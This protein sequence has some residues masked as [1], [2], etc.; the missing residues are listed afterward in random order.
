MYVVVALRAAIHLPSGDQ[1]IPQAYM[2]GESVA[3]PVPSAFTM[4]SGPVYPLL[5]TYAI[6][7]ECGDHCGECAVIFRSATAPFDSV[8]TRKSFEIRSTYAI[9]VP[10]GDDVGKKSEPGFWLVT[11]APPLPSG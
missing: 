9:W 2:F 4:A 8:N 11:W 5:A 7:R 10:S 3:W 1:S 6:C